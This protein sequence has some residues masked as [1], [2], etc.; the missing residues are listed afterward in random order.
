MAKV[1]PGYF[2][3]I[4]GYPG[5]NSVDN[6]GPTPGVAGG[7]WLSLDSPLEPF[8]KLDNQPG[9]MTSHDVVE[10]EKLGYVYH[11]NGKK[12]DTTLPHRAHLG[13]GAIPVK[14]DPAK[15]PILKLGGL[16]RANMGG[17]FMVGVWAKQADGSQALVGTHAVLSRHHITGCANCQNHLEVN[18]HLALHGLGKD[19]AKPENIQVKVYSRSSLRA[20]VGGDGTHDGADE[21]EPTF[22]LI[23]HHLE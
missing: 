3:I 20:I 2:K 19:Q 21:K 4:H 10:T 12:V 17:S 14:Q 5:T 16:S 13:D 9:F 11:Y 1:D 18:A 6:Q 8:R 7:T 15:S 23:T 22:D